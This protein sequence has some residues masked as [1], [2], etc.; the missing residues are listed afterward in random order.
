MAKNRGV[1]ISQLTIYDLQFAICN[2]RPSRRAFT[3]VELLVVITI[4]GI[5]AALITAAAAGAM[6]RAQQARIKV[7]VDQIAQ[8]L[9]TSGSFPPNC[10]IDDV[11]FTPGGDTTMEPL[12]ESQVLTD[13]KRYLKQA[14]PRSREPESLLR[15]LVGDTAVGNA[16]GDV[17]KGGMSAGEAVVFWL[18]GF[19]SDPKY[20]IS[21]EGGPSYS[22][23]NLPSSVTP[24]QA[25][26]IESRK[27]VFPFAVG[28]LEPRT[29]DKFFDESNG[30]YIV[31]NDP[32]G[33]SDAKRR[34][35]FWQYVPAGSEQ[36]YLYFDASRHPASAAF[37]PP[38]ATALS[39]TPLDV[40]SLKKR[41][42]SA[43]ANVL[44]EFCNKDK[45]QIL[46]CGV[47]GEWG[48]FEPMSLAHTTLDNML[49]FPEGP[50]TGEVADTITNFSEG[51]LEASQP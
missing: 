41:S 45:F 19:S 30:R 48:N 1:G 5:L 42:E 40:H 4:I 34:I 32:Q 14:F 51:T 29:A 44:V 46:H 3:L 22:I 31:Y 49:F 20:P 37:D 23:E 21:G 43:S 9:Q 47:D 39:P 17:L 16:N 8:A 6:K 24:V 27:W 25:D 18:G 10:Q 26:P 35:N 7:E 15:A 38:A 11:D 2:R 13:L 50:F 12:D 36:P 28:R 33:P